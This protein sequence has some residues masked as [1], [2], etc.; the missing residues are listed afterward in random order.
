MKIL[1]PVLKD[2]RDK[3]FSFARHFGATTTFANNYNADIGEWMQ[4]QNGDNRPSQCTAYAVVDICSNED[5]FR[6]SE[7]YQ[8][9]KTLQL[10][11]VTNEQWGADARQAAKVPCVY[12]L[13][14]RDDEPAEM[15]SKSQAWSANPSNWTKEHDDKALQFKKPA[16]LPIQPIVQDWFDSIRSALDKGRDEKRVISMASRWSPDFSSAKLTDN[17]QSL[18]WGHDYDCV[19][20]KTIDGLPYLIIKSWQG[21]NYGDNGYCY[22]SRTLCNNL[23]KEWGTYVFTYKKLPDGTTVEQLKAENDLLRDAVARLTTLIQNLYI[24]LSYGFSKLSR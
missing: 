9:M 24:K 11:G 3:R 17:P 13:L 16:Y 8:F 10:M 19:G 21:E 7:D 23:M 12:G 1:K 14:P 20:W 22:M 15:F 6:Y 5:G 4:N 2:W 18:Y